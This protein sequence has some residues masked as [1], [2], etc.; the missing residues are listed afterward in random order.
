MSAKQLVLT[1]IGR[2]NITEHIR[3]QPYSCSPFAGEYDG[4]VELELMNQYTFHYYNTD[5]IMEF[6]THNGIDD[7]GHIQ[8][9]SS[10]SQST[11]NEVVVLTKAK[12]KVKQIVPFTAFNKLV[13][14]IKTHECITLDSIEY[15]KI[16]IEESIKDTLLNLKS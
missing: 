9:D 13:E 3:T 8:L 15:A 12:A 5:F 2:S 16:D 4:C 7:H 6:I 14:Y 1:I 11:S 10:A